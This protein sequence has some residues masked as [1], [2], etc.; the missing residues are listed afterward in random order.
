MSF[1]RAEDL[2]KYYEIGP[3]TVKALDHVQLELDRG[4]LSVVMG[5][6]GSGKSTLLHLLGGLDRP[7][8]GDICIEERHLNDMDENDLAIFRR[9]TVGFVFQAFNLIQSF[10]TLE[11]VGFPMRFMNIPAKERH[12]KAMA[13]M[14]Q[15]GIADRAAHKPA[16]L[17]GGQQQRVAIARALVN[18]PTLILADEPT[19]NLDTASGL[20]VMETLADL[21]RDGRTVMVVTHDPRM[22]QF[23][24]DIIYLLDGKIVSS[25]AY[26]DAIQMS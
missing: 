19:G 18:D 16:E 3:V 4:S 21:N 25:A 17:S 8:Q 20:S 2:S 22:G 7:T 11:N 9:E 26:Q 24:D 10:T 14:E 13:V 23:T 1:I 12:E 15:V 6:S 5:P